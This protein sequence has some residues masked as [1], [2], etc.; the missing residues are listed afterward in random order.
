MV[1]ATDL[2]AYH[3][4]LNSSDRTAMPAVS[5]TYLKDQLVALPRQNQE[6]REAQRY[7]HTR[8][9]R[10]LDDSDFF[11][12]EPSHPALNPGENLAVIVAPSRMP[13][14]YPRARLCQVG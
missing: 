7:A 6:A 5:W 3:I 11:L 13:H 10:L 2:G 8:Q 9:I 4:A 14:S 12:R 1:L